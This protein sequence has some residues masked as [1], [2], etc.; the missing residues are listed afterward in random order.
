L[1]EYSGGPVTVVSATV[2]KLEG[3][4]YGRRMAS[5]SVRNAQVGNR[6][7]NAANNRARA[8]GCSQA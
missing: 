2:A 1:P 7:S 6:N 3:L 4:D 8:A 5:Q